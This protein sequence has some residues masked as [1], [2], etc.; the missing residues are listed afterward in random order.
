ML[1][2]KGFGVL[3]NIMLGLFFIWILV[4][5]GIVFDFVGLGNV[6]FGSFRKVLEKVIEFV[7]Y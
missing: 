2:Y 1:K 6:D 5:Y 3:V 7:Y 4:D